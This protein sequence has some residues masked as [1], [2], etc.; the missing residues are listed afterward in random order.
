IYEILIFSF[1]LTDTQVKNVLSAMQ[2]ANQIRS[3]ANANQVVFIGDSLTAGGPGG[4]PSMSHCYPWQLCQ[5]AGGAFKPLMVAAPGQ[6]ISQQQTLVTGE[7]LP[8]DLTPFKA[9]AAVV[10]CGSNDIVQGRSDTQVIADLTSMCSGLRAA[11][12]K[13]IVATIT[14][15]N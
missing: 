14:P 13:T 1:A 10:C 15:R 12:I 9:T 7:V 11:G 2:T 6:N 3:D 4:A 5:Q 8:L